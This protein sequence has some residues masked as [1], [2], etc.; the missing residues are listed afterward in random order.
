MQRLKVGDVV[1]VINLKTK[2]QKPNQRNQQGGKIQIEAPIHMSKLMLLD[3]E[4]K[5]PTRVR[6]QEKD[7]KKVRVAVKSGAV[8]EASK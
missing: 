1:Q 7:G 4:S 5:K 6:F 8:I 2:H 3:P